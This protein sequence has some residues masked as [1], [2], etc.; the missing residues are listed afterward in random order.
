VS[1]TF[2]GPRGR[3]WQGIAGPPMGGQDGRIPSTQ[4]RLINSGAA[5][6][7]LINLNAHVRPVWATLL[8]ETPDLST[9]MLQNRLF[10]QLY[11][12]FLN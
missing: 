5:L 2:D 3:L 1:G 9:F 4:L 6:T 8:R 12:L 11:C 7:L 10:A